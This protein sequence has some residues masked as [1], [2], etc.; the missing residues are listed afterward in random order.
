MLRLLGGL[1]LLAVTA[2]A[3][4]HFSFTT[5]QPSEVVATLEMSSPGADWAVSG[6][7]AAVANVIL[8]GKPQQ[9]VILFAGPK[10]YGYPVS[11]GRLTPGKHELLVQ[12][13]PRHSA[14][15]ASLQTHNFRVEEISAAH[16]EFDVHANAPVL[17]A[18]LNTIGKFSDI[19]LLLYCE[20]LEVDGEKA[21]QYTVIFSNED[22]GTSTRNLMARWGRTTDIEYVYRRFPASGKATVQGPGH[23]DVEFQGERDGGH[24]MLMPVTD[25]NMIA[26]AKD[27]ALRFRLAPMLVDLSRSSREQIMDR[28]PTT[29]VVMAKELQREGQLRP[30]GAVDG[31][32]ISDLR[33]YL[34]V[35]YAATLT[36]A[37]LTVMVRTKDGKLHAS[38]LGRADVAISRSGHVRTTVELPAGAR[39]EISELLFECRVAPA[40]RHSG[41]CELE[42]VSKVFWLQPDYTPGESIWSSAQRVSLPTGRGISFIF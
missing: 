14:A 8:D 42:G 27:S 9:Q 17:F 26:A 5:S 3:E 38:D 10:P 7:E 24:P 28:H 15:G 6:R 39:G 34:F 16:A 12:R 11:L 35:D 19:P 31:E 20:R 41:S 23:A 18:R 33:N 36:N 40:P 4:S 32:K 21:L 2:S 13:D 37:A 29:Y 25:N 22:G 1:A 30:Y